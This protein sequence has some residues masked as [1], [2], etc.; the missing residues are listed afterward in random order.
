[1]HGCVCIYNLYLLENAETVTSLE[2]QKNGIDRNY[3][4][5]SSERNVIPFAECT[6]LEI[7]RK[8]C[9]QERIFLLN[10]ESNKQI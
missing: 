1:M 9:R 7:A 8:H 6:T 5:K 4:I 3:F 2:L 10:I